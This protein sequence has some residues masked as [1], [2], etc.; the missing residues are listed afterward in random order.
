MHVHGS[1]A[2]RLSD[3]TG[4]QTMNC[5]ETRPSSIAFAAVLAVALG[6]AGPA[7]GDAPAFDL[8]IERSP[9]DAGR[10]T[11]DS[12][13]HRFSANSTVSLRADPQP[14]YQFA[15]WLGDVSD[16]TADQT[17]VVLDQPKVVVAVFQPEPRRRVDNYV[18]SGGGGTDNLTLTAADLMTPGWTPPAG[19]ARTQTQIIP[20]IIDPIPTPEPAT[21]A[22]LAL[23]TLLLRC[24]R[25]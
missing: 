10:V 7:R 19:G 22:I 6:L 9:I 8:L 17:T 25:T 5:Q 18:G 23:G 3:E 4:S 14:G 11:P 21:I 15:Y 1:R 20:I 13:T 24:R 12:G 2:A 16:P